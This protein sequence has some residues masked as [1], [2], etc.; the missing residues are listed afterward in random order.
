MSEF[1]EA[2]LGPELSPALKWYNPPADWRF[3]E[4]Q[5]V[6]RPAK[7]TDFWQKT[8]YGFMPDTG[9]LLYLELTGDFVLETH[10]HYRFVHQY[11]QG[12][13]MVR[14][15]PERWLKAGVEYQGNDAAT[16]GV[17]VTRQRSD[18]SLASFTRRDVYL[19]LKRVRGAVGVYFAEDGESWQMIRLASLPMRGVVQAGVFA[20]SPTDAGCE[21]GFEYLAAWTSPDASL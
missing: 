1:R 9:H 15:G 19:R 2:F 18:W 20:A 6:V 16:I 3:S 4:R 21:I 14:T 13:L 10:V 12:G 11:D 7:D 8:F 5:L 17:V